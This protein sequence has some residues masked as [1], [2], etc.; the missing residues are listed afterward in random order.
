MYHDSA[1]RA[2]RAMEPGRS[3]PCLN[4]MDDAMT[5]LRKRLHGANT[6]RLARVRNRSDGRAFAQRMRQRQRERFIAVAAFDAR[7]QWAPRGAA[8]LA[9]RRANYRHAL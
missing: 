2:P 3:L 5:R 6:R 8:N 7:E 4:G 1:I 9:I